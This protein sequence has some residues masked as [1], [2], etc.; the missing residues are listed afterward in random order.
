MNSGQSLVRAAQMSQRSSSAD[1]T[2][3]RPT[4]CERDRTAARAHWPWSS[5]PRQVHRRSH[6]GVIRPLHCVLVQGAASC[7][8]WIHRLPPW[9]RTQ[10][11]ERSE[12]EPGSVWIGN[13][14]EYLRSKDVQP[15]L[16]EPAGCKH[17]CARRLRPADTDAELPA[18]S[19]RLGDWSRSNVGVHR[20]SLFSG[21]VGVSQLP[22]V[23]AGHASA[24]ASRCAGRAR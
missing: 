13:T 19:M 7:S 3:V 16:A 18:R 20:L 22:S 9:R 2:R 24:D 11:G 14:D 17:R 6:S 10:L 12:P 4:R 1:P 5:C 21:S 15:F 23:W 8:T